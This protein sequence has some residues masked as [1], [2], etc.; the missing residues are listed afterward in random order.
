MLDDCRK[1][2][3]MGYLSLCKSKDFLLNLFDELQKLL[4]ARCTRVP[5]ALVSKTIASSIQVLREAEGSRR[6]SLGSTRI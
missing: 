3:L 5:T 4:S 6:D 2:T 1:R